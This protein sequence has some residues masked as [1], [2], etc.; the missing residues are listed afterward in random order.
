MTGS[1]LSHCPRNI[2]VLA[3][4][5]WTGLCFAQAAAPAGAS[6]RGV[7]VA[8]TVDDLPAHGDDFAG[9]DRDAISRGILAALADNHVEGAWGF[10]NRVWDASELAIFK[11]WLGAGY[12]LGNHTYSHYDLNQ[13]STPAFIADIARQDRLLASLA[14][15]SPLIGK[16]RMFRYPWLDEGSSLARR[17][18]VRR[19]LLGKGYRVAEVTIDYSDWSW[20]DAYGRCRTQNDQKSIQWLLA[21]VN[22]AADRHLNRSVAMARKMFNRDINQILL[23]HIGAFDALTLD[24]ILREWKSKGVEF[25]SLEDALADPIYQVN[26]KLAYTGGMT[27]LMQLAKVRNLDP[28]ALIEPTYTADALSKVCSEPSAPLK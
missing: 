3:I 15:V 25:I 16:R 7:K 28:H 21:H 5:S 12:P 14:K 6:L 18:T 24:G 23:V 19:Y 2:V 11:E 13:V 1:A 17:D 20:T 4:L 27:F 10:T 8:I 9:I 22:D 26:P